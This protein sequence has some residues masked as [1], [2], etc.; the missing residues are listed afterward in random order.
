MSENWYR[1]VIDAAGRFMAK[2]HRTK[3]VESWLIHATVDTKNSNKSKLEEGEG[4]GRTEIQL[5]T[6]AESKWYM[7]WQATGLTILWSL[8]KYYGI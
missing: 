3:A 4:G 6:N 8:L 1:G 5:W 2:W 7:V